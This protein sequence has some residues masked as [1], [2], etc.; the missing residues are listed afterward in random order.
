MKIF[1]KKFWIQIK[2]LLF[3]WSAEALRQAA[4]RLDQI[5]SEKK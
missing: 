1:F 4:A 5:N 3:A 2:T